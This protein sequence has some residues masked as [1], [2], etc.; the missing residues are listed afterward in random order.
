MTYYPPEHFMETDDDRSS[1]PIR[2]HTEYDKQLRLE[3]IP[4]SLIFNNAKVGKTTDTQ[5]IILVNRGWDVLPITEIR[6]VGDFELVGPVPDELLK[7]VMTSIKVAFKPRAKGV[8]T[9][10]VYINT[11]DA[12]GEEFILLSGSADPAS[13]IDLI[14]D[15]VRATNEDLGT[16]NIIQ[17]TTENPIPASNG[18][19]LVVVN[20]TKANTGP[21]KIAFNNDPQLDVVD[22][23]G[24]P[25]E[26]G[27]LSPG[28]LLVGYRLDDTFRLLMDTETMGLYALL[29]S[30]LFEAEEIVGEVQ[31]IREEVIQ[32]AADAR[33]AVESAGNVRFFDTKAQANLYLASVPEGQIVEVMVDESRNGT[34]ARYRKENGVYDFKIEFLPHPT[35]EMVDEAR[36]ALENLDSAVTLIND[37]KA[38]TAADRA[39]VANNLLASNNAANA[40]ENAANTAADAANSI[41]SAVNTATT[42][43]SNALGAANAAGEHVNQAERWA[44]APVGEDVTPGK[45]SAYHWA[46]EAAGAVSLAVGLAVYD[47]KDAA[48]TAPALDAPP[49]AVILLGYNTA[50]DGGG[51]VY[52]AV[53]NEPAHAGKLQ[54]ADGSWWELVTTEANVRQFGGVG[55][56]TTNNYS[57][58]I[59]AIAYAKANNNM[60]VVISGGNFRIGMSLT[61]DHPIRME[62]VSSLVL[63]T[64]VT[65]TF[66]VQPEISES[67]VQAFVLEDTAAIAGL[68]GA[69][70]E[71][72]LGSKI[73]TANAASVELQKLA[74]A[75]V[76]RSLITFPAGRIRLSGTSAIQFNKGQSLIGAGPVATIFEWNGTTCHG[77]AFT[78]NYPGIN[79]RD[80]QIVN[81]NEFDVPT[82]GEAL[83][84]ETQLW[85]VNNVILRGGYIAMFANR[86]GKLSTFNFH[87]FRYQGIH[88]SSHADTYASDG[89]ITSPSSY[90][91]LS[92]ASGPFTPGESVSWPG[93]NGDIVS[94]WTNSAR[95]KAKIPFGRQIPAIG[96]VITGQTSGATATI[97]SIDHSMVE[98]SVRVSGFGETHLFSNVDFTGGWQII[99]LVPGIVT[100]LLN[101]CF[102]NCQ[103][104]GAH[105]T[106]VFMEDCF[107]TKFSNCFFSSRTN[108]SDFEMEI[109]KSSG[110]MLVNTQSVNTGHGFLRCHATAKDTQIIGGH[111]KDFNTKGGTNKYAIMLDN[112]STTIIQ[113]LTIGKDDY[114]PNTANRGI[115]IN[116]GARA[117]IENCDLSG[118]DSGGRVVDN[119]PVSTGLSV[120]RN[121]RGYRTY[122][123]G[124]TEI[125]GGSKVIPHG[126]PYA[127]NE[128]D[129]SV[130]NLA[131]SAVGIQLSN[132]TASQFTIS[133]SATAWVRWEIRSKEYLAD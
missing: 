111:I 42:A 79:V 35:A 127:P 63:S 122:N 116:A 88:L 83:R 104:D 69:K 108:A 80:L 126:L 94:I 27:A 23:A 118:I 67:I 2:A 20:V 4:E 101:I 77:F 76:D 52:H 128:A 82:V 37:A 46:M 9:G 53:D 75:V 89:I 36:E 109:V 50:N 43:A 22:H 44:N 6:A 72:F 18:R 100:K 48:T 114:F 26:E 78:G 14:G 45:K 86:A 28:R 58:I 30:H 25:L 68:K 99:R 21:V 124:V 10:G 120:F 51:G 117:I 90:V 106:A 112:G 57:A 41:G 17:A 133:T 70:A 131:A 71:W 59:A 105:T 54:M 31:S 29:N 115:L 49:S 34:R 132:I 13:S 40:A 16:A 92:G 119:N 97:S 98:G 65:V 15:F 96:T 81:L 56:N 7:D 33:A 85:V 102:Q 66:S 93:S 24:E 39:A 84:F 55:D 121:C 61:I 38:S 47:S 125:T 103:F 87:D 74:N 129:I 60:P 73:N 123:R 19:V 12:S 95:T 11:G 8:S 110:T 3:V 64:G 130:H 91:G 32:S 107:G 113:N 1:F 5:T 62:G